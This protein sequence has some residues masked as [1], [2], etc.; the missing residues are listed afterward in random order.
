FNWS[1]ISPA[2]FGSLFQSIMAS[3]EGQ[4]KRRQIGAH[5]TSE[6]DIM[7]LINSLFLD[8][9]KAELKKTTTKPK[10]LSFQNKLATTKLLD[11]ACGCGN[12]LVVA[13]RELRLL[14]IE[15]LKKYHAKKKG[16][17]QQLLNL[18]Q[19]LK[20]NVDQ[21]H[22]IEIEEWPAR[23]AE[24]AMWLIDHQMNTL[25]GETFGQPVLRLPL[26][27]SAKIHHA[28]ALQTNWND[29]LPAN[30]CAFV[31]GNPPF[32]GHHLQ[33]TDQK[34]DQH[35]IWHDI[36]GS[37]V[38]DYVTCW[39][40]KAV[41][42]IEGTSIQCAFVS[43]N[44]ISQGEQPSIYWPKLIELGTIINFAHRTFKWI[45]EARGKA[46]VHVVII[47]FGKTDTDK[48]LWDYEN[49]NGDNGHRAAVNRI[50][51]NLFE[52]PPE[53]LSNRRNPICPVPGMKYGNK[54]TDGGGFLL[55]PSE[56]AQFISECPATE[57]YIRRYIGAAD[58]L[59]G[60]LRYCLWIPDIL[61]NELR[62]LPLI[63]NRVQQVRDFRLKS[64]AKTTRDYAE[65]PTR[66]RQ[67]AQTEESYILIP[68]HTSETRRYIPFA[69]FD[70]EVIVSDACFFIPNA[71]PYHFGMISSEMHMAWI[72]QF[73]GRIKSDYRYSK[74]IV[75]N[76]YPWPQSPT[77]K[78]T[79]AVES[80]A[81]SVLDARK[82][83]PDQTLAD[84]YDPLAMPKPLRDAHRTLDRAVDKCYRKNPFDS[85]RSRVEHLFTLYQQLTTPLTT[86]TKKKRPRKKA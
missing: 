12:F 17:V 43:T 70:P 59:D 68:R 58:F 54:P 50:S 79:A 8:D 31:M 67:I 35:H 82:K 36:D 41:D 60:K 22:G 47:G 9:L 14:E 45:S 51:P 72:R 23:I 20:V 84:L 34:A 33:S 52:G 65:Y 86:P 1:R 30:Q 37:G 3:D 2:V 71:K 6:R 28:N 74:D 53:V 21:M 81:Q 4:K 39:Y 61:P 7:K 26:K 38:L 78:Q 66:F 29:V 49:D 75:Y 32:I 18:D 55:S 46:H 13:Y 83:Y 27:K 80:A 19:L 15:V 5:Y 16:E 62:S 69:Y 57:K 11:P 44:S 40:R 56:R 10:L 48:H 76:N 42:Y 64:K 73:C 63:A 25:A 24:V 77:E 85:E